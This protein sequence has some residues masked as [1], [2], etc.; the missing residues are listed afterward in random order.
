MSVEETMTFE[1]WWNEPV[2]E[3]ITRGQNMSDGWLPE[4]IARLAFR[5]GQEEMRER[6]VARARASEGLGIGYDD[7][8]ALPLEGDDETE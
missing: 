3:H 5:A 2:L 1:E 4:E 6:V 8:L 7:I